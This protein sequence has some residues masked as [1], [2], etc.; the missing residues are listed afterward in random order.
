MIGNIRW[1]LW[2]NGSLALVFCISAFV[3]GGALN[4]FGIFPRTEA[5]LIGI[6]VAPWL[7][8]SI[9]HLMNNL[10]GMSIF[11]LLTLSYGKR[12]FLSASAIIIF[13]GGFGV[14]L[15]GRPNIHIGASGWIFGLWALALGN[16]WFHRSLKTLLIA[17]VVII[18]WGG[19]AIG[20]L[21]SDPRIAFEAHL[22][23][24]AAGLLAAAAL[25]PRSRKR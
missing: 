14:W 2:L 16:A 12:Y 7:H 18:F 13:V 4:G 8:G 9:E 6:A 3:F 25:K 24:A 23:G 21:P 22:F 11:A 10:I 20:V 17:I 5:G 1:L 19:M 15:L